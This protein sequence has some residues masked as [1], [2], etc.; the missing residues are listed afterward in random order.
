MFGVVRPCRG[1]MSPELREAWM[2][3]LCGLCL[4][5]RDRHGQWA[6]LATNVDAVLVSALV[7]AQ[8][9]PAAGTTGGAGGRRLAGPCPLRGMR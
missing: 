6:R 8:T 4:T 5:L 7:A 3:H 1:R 2:S 9:G